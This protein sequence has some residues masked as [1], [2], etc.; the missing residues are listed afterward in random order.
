MCVCV[1][2]YSF[3][4]VK[5]PSGFIVYG[6]KQKGRIC[7]RRRIMYVQQ[8]GLMVGNMKRKKRI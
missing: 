3:G 4:T 8:T 1:G 2:G 5:I 7:M 6:F